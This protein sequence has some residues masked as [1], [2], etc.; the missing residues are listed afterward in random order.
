MTRDR[1]HGL[2][3]YSSSSVG[4]RGVITETYQGYVGTA[5]EVPTRPNTAVETLT[6]VRATDER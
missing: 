2:Q 3:F 1:A 4:V 5:L 6:R